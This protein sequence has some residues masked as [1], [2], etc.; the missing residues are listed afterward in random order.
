MQT[1]NNSVADVTIIGGGMVGLSL[2]IALLQQNLS[3]V[4]ID[5]N[6]IS[7]EISEQPQA[8]VSALTRA[9]ENWLQQLNAWQAIPKNRCSAY[10]KMQI[11]NANS[12]AQLH[13][14]ASDL[15]QPNLGHII[16]NSVIC[17]ALATSLYS[18]QSQEI[19]TKEKQL[20]VLQAAHCQK[21]EI[22]ADR[23]SIQVYAKEQSV[24]QTIHSSIV[25][26]AD[27]GRSWLRQQLSIPISAYPYQ[28]DA[29]VALVESEKTHQH[30]AWQKFTEDGPLAFLPMKPLNL[31]SIVWSCEHH[32]AQQLL[33]MEAQEFTQQLNS[34][35]DN[36][37]GQLK[38]RSPLS[39]FPL[40]AT[41]ARRYTG[42]RY[43]LVGDAAH[44]I[45]PLAGQGVNLGF[46]DAKALS[47]TLGKMKKSGQDLG[48]ANQLRVYER[49]RYGD[50]LSV[51]LAMTGL[52]KMFSQQKNVSSFAIQEGMNLINQSAFIKRKLMKRAMGL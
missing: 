22:D 30:C 32:K 36:R 34:Q 37:F 46:L 25:V 50:N 33:Q 11:W 17:A 44:T 47:E 23:V 5:A 1:D 43:A 35:M 6:E 12:K 13:F 2:A 9:S 24:A 14:E 26:A 18:L 7:T 15:A 3:V 45:H 8:R 29:L 52:Y 28:Q 20:R 40:I 31:H 27:G 21:V 39:S 48:E 16:E 49:A 19:K 42:H 38:L 41:H 10:R 51:Q 4:I